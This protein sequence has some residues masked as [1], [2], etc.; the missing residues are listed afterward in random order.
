MCSIIFGE[1]TPGVRVEGPIIK[2]RFENVLTYT[3]DI[4]S[5]LGKSVSLF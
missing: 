5:T 2:I 3:P 4:V 1:R